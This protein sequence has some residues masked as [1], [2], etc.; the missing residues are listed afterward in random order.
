MKRQSIVLGIMFAASGFVAP[1]VAM[2][3]SQGGMLLRSVMGKIKAAGAAEEGDAR[4]VQTTWLSGKQQERVSVGARLL[5]QQARNMSSMDVELPDSAHE[6]RWVDGSEGDRTAF[7][8]AQML[9][10]QLAAERREKGYDADSEK[11]EDGSVA[12]ESEW[13]LPLDYSRVAS[14]KNTHGNVPQQD[15]VNSDEY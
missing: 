14:C 13:E 12:D 4:V 15:D 7:P 2:Q 5:Q 8:G 9:K 11:E 1:V 10:A 6:G 3:P